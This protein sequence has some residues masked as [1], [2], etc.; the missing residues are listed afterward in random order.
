MQV[1]A[2]HPHDAVFRRVP[3]DYW[4]AIVTFIERISNASP[5]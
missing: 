2:D 5:G 4:A 1:F 3:E